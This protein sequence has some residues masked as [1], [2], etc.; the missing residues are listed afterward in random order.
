[1]EAALQCSLCSNRYN[2]TDRIPRFLP[3]GHTFCNSCLISLLS[4]P[5][6]ECPDDL[7]AIPYPSPEL[8]PKNVSLL[9]LVSKSKQF[10]CADHKK[11][12]EYVCM[13]EKM[14]ICS[15][16]AL[17]GSHKDHDVRSLEEVMSE[18]HMR[19]RCLLD[20]LEMIDKTETEI[21]NNVMEYLEKVHKKFI[22]K[23]A[24]VEEKAQKNFKKLRKLIDQLEKTTLESLNKNIEYIEMTLQTS[25]D[26]PKK[27]CGQSREWKEIAKDMLDLVD[28]KCE[29]HNNVVFEILGKDTNELLD[30]GEKLLTDLDGVRSISS[31]KFDELVDSLRVEFSNQGVSSLCKVYPLYTLSKQDD[32]TNDTLIGHSP[33]SSL[34]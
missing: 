17:L 24:E 26:L 21:D 30:Y 13:T 10:L 7:V 23:K 22:L 27:I 11:K 14:K 15:Y 8:L 3:C 34:V 9:K 19:A 12:L 18:V 16:C 28:A 4:H 6:P 25:K 1:M 33:E 20:I 31:Q 32:F 5:T 2:T 29:D